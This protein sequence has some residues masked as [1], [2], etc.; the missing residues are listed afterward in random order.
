MFTTGM[1]PLRWRP[2]GMTPLRWHPTGMTFHWD[3]V[4]VKWHSSQTCP[5]YSNQRWRGGWGA[6]DR[7]QGVSP[8]STPPTSTHPMP[9]APSHTDTHTKANNFCMLRIIFK[10]LWLLDFQM[11][12]LIDRWIFC[13]T[14]NCLCL[15]MANSC[16]NNHQKYQAICSDRSQLVEHFVGSNNVKMRVKTLPVL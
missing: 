10:V 8:L 4:P 12:V 13:C 15:K 3:N 7:C 2:T 5:A 14:W 9:P 11:V 1:T 6:Q 16:V